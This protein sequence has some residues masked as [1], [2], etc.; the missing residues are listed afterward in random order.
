M[1]IWTLGRTAEFF[2]DEIHEHDLVPGDQ[3]LFDGATEIRDYRLIQFM[4]LGGPSLWRG[5][6]CPSIYFL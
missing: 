4:C 5:G 3:V 1:K 6:C 2:L